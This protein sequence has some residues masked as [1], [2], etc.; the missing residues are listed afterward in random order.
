MKNWADFIQVFHGVETNDIAV[1][2]ENGV[3]TPKTGDYSLRVYRGVWNN[4]AWVDSNNN[5]ISAAY[6][7]VCTPT[8]NTLL[9][10]EWVQ[11]CVNSDGSVVYSYYMKIDSCDVVTTPPALPVF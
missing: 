6:E 3:G 4:M 9:L 2:C 11:S 7:V 8:F 5:P 10:N 1:S